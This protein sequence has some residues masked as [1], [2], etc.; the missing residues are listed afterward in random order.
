MAFRGINFGAGFFNVASPTDS[1]SGAR[2][3]HNGPAATSES[4]LN[5]LHASARS[6][7]P[8][9]S[10]S[11]GRPSLAALH[12]PSPFTPS[13]RSFGTPDS[14]YN[15]SFSFS[16]PTPTLLHSSARFPAQNSPH[17]PLEHRSYKAPR[18]RPQDFEDLPPS[19]AEDDDEEDGD[20]NADATSLT[21]LHK[22]YKA[23]Q[24]VTEVAENGCWKF[25]CNRCDHPIATSIAQRI[26]LVSPGQFGSLDAHQRGRRCTYSPKFVRGA[27]APPT[28]QNAPPETSA[29]EPMDVD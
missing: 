7:A 15:S 2:E 10:T 16:F 12:I 22:L 25:L 13:M 3:G 26:P 17:S 9:A 14:G 20:E 5:I 1:T 23:G 21:H 24:I 28:H 6:S 11:S 27:S 8:A 18:F 29:P 4:P 19:D